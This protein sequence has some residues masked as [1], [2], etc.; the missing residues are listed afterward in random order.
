MIDLTTTQHCRKGDRV[1]IASGDCAITNG[2]KRLAEA[3]G[4]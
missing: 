4:Y 2:L 3:A 1:R